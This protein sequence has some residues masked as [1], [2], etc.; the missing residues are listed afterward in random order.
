M[1]KKL[2]KFGFETNI[3][4]GE[5]L[6]E[7]P[8]YFSELCVLFCKWVILVSYQHWLPKKLPKLGFETDISTGKILQESPTY[9]SE[10]CVFFCKWVILVNYQHL[11]GE[12]VTQIRLWNWYFNWR[13]FTGIIDILQ[14]T[15][16]FVLQMSDFC[17]ISTKPDLGNVFRQWDVDNLGIILEMSMA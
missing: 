2:P 1:A 11:M 12:K 4:T 10:L 5:I 6:Q 9:F 7:S 3:S 14:W 8:T 13:N 17:K 16:C 15:V